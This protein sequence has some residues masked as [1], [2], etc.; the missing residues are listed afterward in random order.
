MAQVQVSDKGCLIIWDFDVL[1]VIWQVTLCSSEM[2]LLGA[3]ASVTEGLRD[4][5]GLWHSEGW[6]DIHT[7]AM[8]TSHCCR[9]S[10]M[11]W[12]PCER[13]HRGY[14]VGAVCWQTLDCG[15]RHQHCRTT[16]GLPWRRQ[17]TG[18][19]SSSG[20]SSSSSCSCCSISNSVSLL[21][22]KQAFYSVVLMSS[23]LILVIFVTCCII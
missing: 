19:S 13:C 2:C 5:V 12:A 3:G 22:F 14:W 11:S 18:I 10:T 7:D 1:T 20:S 9:P 17:H 6:R 4:H 16:T 23:R 15:C 8:S 21:Q